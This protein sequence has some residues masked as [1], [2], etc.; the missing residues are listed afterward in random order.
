MQYTHNVPNV[1]QQYPNSKRVGVPNAS[2]VNPSYHS[3]R[4][5]VPN[6]NQGQHSMTYSNQSL[7]AYHQHQGSLG[8]HQQNSLNSGPGPNTV[9]SQPA[10]GYGT[11]FEN[12]RPGIPA[13]TRPSHA[14]PESSQQNLNTM[15]QGPN[16]QAPRFPRVGGASVMAN[17]QGHGGAILGINPQ[18][19]GQ[20]SQMFQQPQW[21]QGRGN[22]SSGRSGLLGQKPDNIY[23]SHQQELLGDQPR[24][25]SMQPSTVQSSHHPVFSSASQ[26][27]QTGQ[28]G[29]SQAMYVGKRHELVQ[30]SQQKNTLSSNIQNTRKPNS[31][32]NSQ[33][34]N[35]SQNMNSS[36]TLNKNYKK[37]SLSDCHEKV[38]GNKEHMMKCH[39]PKIFNTSFSV[40]NPALHELRMRALKELT[41][42]ILGNT[43]NLDDLCRFLR[44][45][46]ILPHGMPISD[47]MDESFRAFCRHYGY[48]E[49]EVFV[50][51]TVNSPALLLH[52]KALSC[53]LQYITPV[54]RGEFRNLFHAEG[55][56]FEW[57]LLKNTKQ[58]QQ[59]QQN[60]Q[61][62][63]QQNMH[64]QRGQNMQQTMAPFPPQSF[65]IS[66][67]EES[68]ESRF[69]TFENQAKG[70]HSSRGSNSYHD[71]NPDMGS[72]Q[73]R[74]FDYEQTH[75]TG[76][77]VE[78]EPLFQTGGLKK[79]LDEDV[80]SC[81]HSETE[82]EEQQN[83][84]ASNLRNR[85]LSSSQVRKRRRI[86]Q[87]KRKRKERKGQ[88]KIKKN[89]EARR[90]D[91]QIKR[92]N[93]LTT[94]PVPNCFQTTDLKDHAYKFHL[95]KIFDVDLPV[96]DPNL[97]SMRWKSLRDL[98]TFV[99]S[100]DAHIEDLLEFFRSKNVMPQEAKITP[101]MEISMRALC[102][103]QGLQIPH[104]F[105]IWPPNSPAILLHWRALLGLLKYVSVRFQKLFKS[106]FAKA[107]I[108]G[109]SLEDVKNPHQ[110]GLN[111]V[112]KEDENIHQTSRSLEEDF[113]YGNQGY[114]EKT[115]NFNTAF[116]D[117]RDFPEY[118]D[119]EYSLSHQE[120][121]GYHRKTPPPDFE[122]QVLPIPFEEPR[123]PQKISLMDSH[124][125]FG[126][127]CMMFNVAEINPSELLSN[128]AVHARPNV[129]VDIIGG[130][131]VYSNPKSFA[132]GG[133]PNYPGWRNCFGVDASAAPGL[134]QE[135][136][137]AV[138]VLTNS[139]DAAFGDIGL[140]RSGDKELWMEQE[141][142]F[143][144]L[145]TL[146]TPA[147]PMILKVTGPHGDPYSFDVGSRVR[148]LVRRHCSPE[149][150][151]HLCNFKGGEVM[152]REWLEDFPNCYFGFTR[153][154]LDFDEQQMKGL[155]A[156]PDDRLLLESDVVL[157]G[158]EQGILENSPLF[159]GEVASA[160]ATIRNDS[161]DSIAHITVSN[162][163]R[164]Y[165]L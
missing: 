114:E 58:Q 24:S 110:K 40:D 116:N 37:C 83:S 103:H 90:I 122:R 7:Q 80:S 10:Y 74:V 135:E 57:E 146:S 164:L 84:V 102:Q 107:T 71:I 104:Q 20:R 160:V 33:Q 2:V 78:H 27:S 9:Q 72:D 13:Y 51:H 28:S 45:Q 149:Q 36:K 89:Y 111:L 12:P 95:P 113:N 143:R 39:L 52:W 98:T 17:P 68:R 138:S 41:M 47:K 14:V 155:R 139:A 34:S 165:N 91:R 96:S 105:S 132:L 151:I 123:L 162:T 46:N 88:R 50:L 62:Q 148:D 99:L 115:R 67:T 134:L 29:T 23:Q 70:F 141:M 65:S 159:L 60:M 42:S 59:G 112:K 25:Q 32:N 35:G 1:R 82:E 61:Q 120:L 18:N 85:S 87:K 56:E 19:H 136:F 131:V 92:L 142:K 140:D 76:G 48:S 22:I 125:Y 133:F 127:L 86:A 43:S 152:V 158:E 161:L 108:N 145:L 3:S 128:L 118:R 100:P 97:H 11:R 119:Q 21:G 38:G 16:Q 156:V 73:I 109:L 106:S 153:R 6:P 63:G 49:P 66:Q 53:L 147:Q 64:Q 101:S 129:P 137:E 126:R 30:A 81:S 93:A 4:Q 69:K 26:R 77:R 130:T 124:F 44:N 150:H 157:V 55:L 15:N 75:P 79:D 163:C 117:D 121:E 94:C 144:Q 5:S 54:Q 8:Y 154:V 31:G